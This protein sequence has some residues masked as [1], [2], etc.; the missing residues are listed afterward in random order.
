MKLSFCR[1]FLTNFYPYVFDKSHPNTMAICKFIRL[2]WT[3]ILDF[4]VF[5]ALRGHNYKLTFGL[6]CCFY[7]KFRPKLIH[8]IDSR[9]TG[10]RS[11]SPR[12]SS[13]CS[14]RTPTRYKAHFQWPGTDVLIFEIF[15]PK[16]AFFTKLFKN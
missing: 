2:L 8:Q 5:R 1:K 10:C 3:I 7:C 9:R 16:M 15:L 13:T 4:N 14:W 12:K 11:T 6:I